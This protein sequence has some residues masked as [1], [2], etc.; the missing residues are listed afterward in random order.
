MFPPHGMGSWLK[1]AD[2]ELNVLTRP[3]L[4]RRIPDK[5]TL[6]KEAANWEKERNGKLAKIDWQF[7]TSDA[8]IKL[9]HPHP[10]NQS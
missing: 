7:R 4:D 2:I 6:A 10:K 5:P 8:R 9:K 1:M 3:C